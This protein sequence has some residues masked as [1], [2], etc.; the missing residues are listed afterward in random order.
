MN[1]QNPKNQQYLTRSKRFLSHNILKM[2][3]FKPIPCI[4][5]KYRRASTRDHAPIAVAY[6]KTQCDWRASA[7][8]GPH[9][10]SPQR[11]KPSPL[12]LQ[13]E[14]GRSCGGGVGT[15]CFALTIVG[16]VTRVW[17][18]LCRTSRGDWFASSVRARIWQ[19]QFIH[20]NIPEQTALFS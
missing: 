17:I 9:L 13:Q 3:H 5:D 12:S 20:A 19:C 16:L 6:Q 10:S 1:M 7:Q 15:P 11:G 4:S 8:Q 2:A 18:L 14:K